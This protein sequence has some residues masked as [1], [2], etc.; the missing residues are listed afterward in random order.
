MLVEGDELYFF[1][2]L[3][4]ILQREQGEI[5][6]LLALD[7]ILVEGQICHFRGW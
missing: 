4:D 2:D 6:Q 7:I 5:I 1:K 3:F